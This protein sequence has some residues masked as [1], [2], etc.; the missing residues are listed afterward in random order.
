[1]QFNFRTAILSTHFQAGFGTLFVGKLG[2]S[3]FTIPFILVVWLWLLGT[4]NSQFGYEVQR[5]HVCTAA[6]RV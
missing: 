1:M 5:M 6:W 2:L 3:P 4:S